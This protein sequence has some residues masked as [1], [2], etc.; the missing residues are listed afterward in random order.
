M[1]ISAQDFPNGADIKI[2][3]KIKGC[4]KNYIWLYFCGLQDMK[5]VASVICQIGSIYPDQP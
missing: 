5:L 4:Q 3:G 1:K 2:F